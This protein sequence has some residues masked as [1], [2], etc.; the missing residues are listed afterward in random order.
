MKRRII[1]AAMAI[2]AGSAASAEVSLIEV[3]AACGTVDEVEALLSVN[4]PNSQ[5]IGRGSSSRGDT[6]VVLLTGTTG[7]WA[8]VATMSPT[9]VCVVASGRDWTKVEAGY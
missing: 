4:M 8:M 5:A 2:F 6:L 3:P 9:N 7:H 1:I